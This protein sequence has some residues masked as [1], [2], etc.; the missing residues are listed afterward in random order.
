MSWAL[1][2]GFFGL[3]PFLALRTN[4]VPSFLYVTPEASR[5]NSYSVLP[6]KFD[7]REHT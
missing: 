7:L 6:N 3:K 5:L 2:G 4:Y 1:D